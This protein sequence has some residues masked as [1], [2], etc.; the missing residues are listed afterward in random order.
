MLKKR[1][2]R[3]KIFF[4]HAQKKDTKLLFKWANDYSVR[5]ISL[6]VNKI[7]ILE[8]KK[9]FD[10]R[11]NNHR[12]K[13]L[14]FYTKQNY[15]GQVRLDKMKKR[16]LITYSVDKKYRGKGYGKEI[17]KRTLNLIKRQINSGEVFAK[18]VK[19]NIASIKI[20]EALSFECYYRNKFYYYKKK[21]N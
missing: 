19:N 3:N 5:K 6:K 2:K 8:H 11:L 7:S 14:I 9:W 18:V 15:I 4:R 16:N 21:L 20:F 13:I 17:L 10:K 1:K 12:C